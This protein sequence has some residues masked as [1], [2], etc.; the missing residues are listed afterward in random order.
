MKND[1][2]V[3]QVLFLSM[4]FPSPLVLFAAV[5]GFACSGI[6][7]LHPSRQLSF[8]LP[9]PPDGFSTDPTATSLRQVLTCYS[10]KGKC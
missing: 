4:A 10:I 7:L 8:G 9:H 3:F 2:A 1:R 5:F 6:W